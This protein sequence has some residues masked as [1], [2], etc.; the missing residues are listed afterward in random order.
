MRQKK[1]KKNES[2]FDGAYLRSLRENINLSQ[3][4]LATELGVTQTHI[5]HLELDS[6]PSIDLALAVANFFGADLNRLFRRALTEDMPETV[7]QIMTIAR[8]LESGN[9]A[10]VLE[11]ARRLYADQRRGLDREQILLELIRQRYGDVESKDLMRS[12][13]HLAEVTNGR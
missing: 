2:Q 1:S 10:I 13:V 9:Q 4:E 6:Q 3:L 11:I 12:V 7:C 8:L 5:S